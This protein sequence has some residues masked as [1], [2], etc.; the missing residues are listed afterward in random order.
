M[1]ATRGDADH[2]RRRADLRARC[3]DLLG[4]PLGDVQRNA[5]EHPP[6]A[7]RLEAGNR[8]RVL[9]VGPA[10][11]YFK[12]GVPPIWLHVYKEFDARNRAEGHA[13][14]GVEARA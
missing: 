13:G 1:P 10:V 8:A 7:D 11:S 3:D 12:P 5:V 14:R 4:N 6:F 2:D 9:A